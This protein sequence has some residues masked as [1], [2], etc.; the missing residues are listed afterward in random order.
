MKLEKLHSNDEHFSSKNVFRR[1]YILI[2]FDSLLQSFSFFKKVA[3]LKACNF[4][5]DETLAHVFSREF[6][7]ISKNTFF[8][9]HLPTTALAALNNM[10]EHDLS[11]KNE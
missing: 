2:T 3:V 1:G 4:I 8:T 7:E 6:C 5:K 11:K 10:K 9:E